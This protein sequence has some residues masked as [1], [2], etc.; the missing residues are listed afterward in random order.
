MRLLRAKPGTGKSVMSGHVINYLRDRD[1]HCC[2]FSFSDR[3]QQKAT[4]NTFLRS[5]AWQMARLHREVLSALLKISENWQ[6]AAFNKADHNPIW[7]RLYLKGILK[8]RLNRTQY[9]VIDSLDECKGASELVTLLTKAQELWPLCILITSRN[10]ISTYISNSNPRIEVIPETILEEDTNE[11]ISLFLKVN[12]DSLPSPS[13]PGREAT[14]NQ[15]IQNSSGCFLWVNLVLK[16]LRQVNTSAEIRKVLTSNPEEMD[17]LYYKILTSMA[18]AKFGKDLAKSILTWTTCSFR[19]LSIEEIHR[20]IE[21][22]IKDTIDNVERSVSTCCGSLVY[23]D[24]CKRVQLIHLTASDFLTRLG[25]GSEFIIERAKG[26]RNLALVCLQYLSGN[27]MRGPRQRKLSAPKSGP[28]RS[29]FADYA[30]KYLFQHLVY[31]K[32]YGD[33]VLIALSKF[34]GSANVLSW[35]EYL[36]AKSDLQRVFQAGKT[37]NSL[38]N[39]R[40]RHTPP[41]G[42]SKDLSLLEQ[43]GK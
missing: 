18:D 7:R 34:L 21:L 43:W 30:C 32:S 16:D 6:D 12:L 1:R 10:P 4:I 23:I 33:E 39:R 22:D 11:D 40:A 25:V 28:E 13:S 8:L 27:E 3:D 20:A 19:P 38:L 29:P 5:M 2:F 14:A 26:H 35:I 15:I 42:L 17:T 36:A 41:V 24:T 9:W 31:I 37:I